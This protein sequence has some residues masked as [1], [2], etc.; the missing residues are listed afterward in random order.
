MEFDASVGEALRPEPF[1]LKLI[2][3]A[4]EKLPKN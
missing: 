3:Y 4:L 1:E 2:E